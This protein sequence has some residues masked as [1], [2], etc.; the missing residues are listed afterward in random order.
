MVSLFSVWLARRGLRTDRV[1]LVCL[2]KHIVEQV[3][4]P[5]KEQGN[6]EASNRRIAENAGRVVSGADPADEYAD[7]ADKTAEEKKGFHTNKKEVD[8]DARALS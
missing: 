8:L 4:E 7:K 5:S 2:P 6:P 1:L 3:P